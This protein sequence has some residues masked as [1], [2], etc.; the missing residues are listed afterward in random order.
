M[1]WTSSTLNGGMRAEVEVILIGVSNILLNQGTW[2]G[3]CITIS[4]LGV[5]LLGEEANVVTLGTD[6]NSPLD[7]FDVRD[8]L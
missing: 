7:L 1:N 8:R 4:S 5:A 2:K 6:G 3:I